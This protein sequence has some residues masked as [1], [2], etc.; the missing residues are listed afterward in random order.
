[1]YREFVLT[2]GL[3]WLTS[4]KIILWN[5]FIFKR[6]KHLHIS[7]YTFIFI[8]VLFI[9]SHITQYLVNKTPQNNNNVREKL[10]K[11]YVHRYELAVFTTSTKSRNERSKSMWCSTKVETNK[12]RETTSMCMYSRISTNEGKGTWRKFDIIT[13]IKGGKGERRHESRY[14]KKGKGTEL[15]P[16]AKIK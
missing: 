12:L 9:E 14:Q 2:V 10:R 6:H 16:C 8:Y 7:L 11:T 5:Y 4:I 13:K 1:M 15:L 3:V